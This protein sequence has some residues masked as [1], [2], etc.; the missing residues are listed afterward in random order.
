MQH[1]PL[2]SLLIAEAIAKGSLSPH[3]LV[4]AENSW[5]FL[6]SG[7]K[8]FFENV[9]KRTFSTRSCSN[10][11]TQNPF[12]SRRSRKEPFYARSIN[13]I[14]GGLPRAELHSRAAQQILS[15]VERCAKLR[16]A[17]A[18]YIPSFL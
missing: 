5:R 7:G 17:M 14:V 6:F 9:L 16:A 2:T 12:Y 3:H 18:E 10:K 8:L 4:I 1:A 15:A 13:V 11:H